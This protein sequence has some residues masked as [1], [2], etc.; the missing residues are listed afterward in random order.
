MQTKEKI[1]RGKI[2]QMEANE[3][4]KIS[5]EQTEIECFRQYRKEGRNG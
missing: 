2:G 4:E 3:R 5:T 1:T